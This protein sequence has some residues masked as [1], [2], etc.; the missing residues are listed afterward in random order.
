MKNTVKLATCAAFLAHISCG[1]PLFASEPEPGT[2]HPVA[3]TKAEEELDA[4]KAPGTGK[5]KAAA[6]IDN[7]TA[8]VAEGLKSAG[9]AVAVGGAHA[10]REGEKVT[11]NL[12][13]ESRKLA[14]QFK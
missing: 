5:G 11:T 13:T 9:K 6:A 12:A 8:K 2:N 4:A 7:A 3:K 14:D 1:A 10:A